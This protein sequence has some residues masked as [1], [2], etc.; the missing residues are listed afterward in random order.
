MSTN[1]TIFLTVEGNIY[2]CGKGSAG[3]LGSKNKCLCVTCCPSLVFE[4][5]EDNPVV[6]IV[7]GDGFSAFVTDKKVYCSL[8]GMTNNRQGG[9]DPYLWEIWTPA[10]GRRR[11]F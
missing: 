11:I 2:G 9:L 10:D 5:G 1:H 8:P 6:D 3:Q 7:V 4:G